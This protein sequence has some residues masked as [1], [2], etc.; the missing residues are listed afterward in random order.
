MK[1]NENNKKIDVSFTSISL[2]L[3]QVLAFL[4]KKTYTK[5]RSESCQ[6]AIR[7]NS[8]LIK[9]QI[10]NTLLKLIM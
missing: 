9:N 4:V 3:L 10:N 7:L 1:N 5:G 2:Q 6:P 8:L